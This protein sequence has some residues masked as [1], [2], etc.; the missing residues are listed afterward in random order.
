ME[1]QKRH[2]FPYWTLEKLLKWSREDQLRLFGSL[3]APDPTEMY[4][5]Y[6]IRYPLYIEEDI[7]GFFGR[8]DSNGRGTRHMGKCYHPSLPVGDYPGQG[9]NWWLK[10]RDIQRFSRFGWHIG[11]S[12]RD[13]RPALIMEYKCFRNLSKNGETGLHDEIRRIHPGLYM[14]IA[15]NEVWPNA[16]FMTAWDFEH[17]RTQDEVFFLYG[18]VG[19]W[20]GVDNPSAEPEAI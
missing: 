11:P 16:P 10:G 20:H 4:G 6:I 2:D 17:G 19:P 13:Q 9:Y 3:D 5:E 15:H 14:G 18:P 7:Q 1:E 12:R 8:P